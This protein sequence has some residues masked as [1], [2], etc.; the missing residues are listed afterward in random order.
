MYYIFDY[1]SVSILPIEHFMY[2]PIASGYS[3]GCFGGNSLGYTV[4]LCRVLFWGSLFNRIQQ[5]CTNLIDQSK[6]LS[7]IK[8]L[9]VEGYYFS[10]M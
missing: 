4:Y 3:V 8:E 6:N 10:S 2:V 1:F 5:V 7:S 9:L